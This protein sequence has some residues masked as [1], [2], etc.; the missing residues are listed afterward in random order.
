MSL[1]IPDALYR[2]HLCGASISTMEYSWPGRNLLAIRS[3]FPSRQ[4]VTQ[5]H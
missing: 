1:H 3:L 5:E 2:K 4:Q